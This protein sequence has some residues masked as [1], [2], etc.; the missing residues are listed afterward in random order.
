MQRLSKTHTHIPC[1]FAVFKNDPYPSPPVSCFPILLCLPLSQYMEHHALAKWQRQSHKMCMATLRKGELL[2]ET[3]FIEKLR[4]E[5]RVVLTS[6]TAPTT[7]MMVALVHHSPDEHGEHQ[8]GAWVFVSRDA[9]H[10]FDF[11]HAAMEIIFNYCL[12]ERGLP[13]SPDFCGR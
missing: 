2:V 4:H 5:A 9:N 10:D 11:H 8:T 7:T 6:A 1:Y 3:D 13:L 12:T